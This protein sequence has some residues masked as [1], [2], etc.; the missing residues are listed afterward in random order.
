MNQQTKFVY[1]KLFL[2]NNINSVLNIGFRADSDKTIMNECLKRGISWSVLEVYE[3]NCIEMKKHN[4]DVICDDVKNIGNHPNNYDAII[5]LHGP[6]HLIWEDF[7]KIR[8]NIESKATKIVIYQAPIGKY[9]QEEM[10]GNIFE[11][12]LSTLTSSMFSELGYNVID[13]DKNGEYTFSAY[14]IK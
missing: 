2:D 6:E 14:L 9:D 7:L 10:Y 3:P 13:H 11:R 1:E 5:W 4:M 8:K 12:H